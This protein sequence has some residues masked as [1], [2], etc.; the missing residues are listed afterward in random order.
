M[1]NEKPEQRASR[2]DAPGAIGG[3][4]GSGAGSPDGDG[5]G[6]GGGTGGDGGGADGSQQRFEPPDSAAVETQEHEQIMREA[7]S[8]V[9]PD[10]VALRDELEKTLMATSGENVPV[11]EVE[12]AGIVGVGIGF[13]EPEAIASGL[14]SNVE[15]G[16]AALN[17]YTVE[18]M[19][20]DRLHVRSP[21]MLSPWGVVF[22]T[23]PSP[24]RPG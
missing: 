23:K 17:L 14:A 4:A 8:G 1:A 2:F 7:L 5:D 9:D 21:A 13:P 16:K 12:G 18:P 6:G 3:G 20:P 19:S 11:Q 24:P 22:A 10:I 15:L